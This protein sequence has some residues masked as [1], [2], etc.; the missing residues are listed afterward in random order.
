MYLEHSNIINWCRLGDIELLGYESLLHLVLVSL[1]IG[2]VNRTGYN[3][4]GH[5]RHKLIVII[6]DDTVSC[7]DDVTLVNDR[8]TTAMH[9]QHLYRYLV[10]ELLRVDCLTPDYT[11]ALQ[12]SGTFLW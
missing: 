8:T 5:Q 4:Q 10:A 1:H 6:L 9:T 11:F 3:F 2:D 7:G 12:S